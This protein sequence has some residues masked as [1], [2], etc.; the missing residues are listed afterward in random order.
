MP[1]LALLAAV[2]AAALNPAGRAGRNGIVAGVGEEIEL[3]PIGRR[4][5]FFRVV[6]VDE[7][8]GEVKLDLAERWYPGWPHYLPKEDKFKYFNLGLLGATALYGLLFWDYGTSSFR[9]GSEGWF[10]AD[11]DYGGTDKV[12]HAWTTYLLCNVFNAIYRHWGYEPEEAALRGTLSGLGMVTVVEVGD[13]FSRAHGFSWE[14]QLANFVGA[15]MAYLRLRVP[16]V[17]R[18]ADFRMEWIPS[19]SLRYGRRSDWV[20]DYSGYKFLLAF[21]PEGIFDTGHPAMRLLEFH[22]GYY[23]RGFLSPDHHYFDEKR[24]VVYAGVGINVTSLLEMTVGT[25]AGRVFDYIQV[26]YTY[27]PVRKSWTTPQTRRR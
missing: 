19:P 3:D 13:G 27:L 8:R 4:R 25:D 17:A 23:T 20:T 12:G 10:G 26:P 21:K 5:Y 24:R 16:E 22:L 1:V 9:F 6:E 15:G 7:E 14:D 2:I 11:T 18:V